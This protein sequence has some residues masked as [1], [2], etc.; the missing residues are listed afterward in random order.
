[1][2]I[3]RLRLLQRLLQPSVFLHLPADLPGLLPVRIS[4]CQLSYPGQRIQQHREL[5]K[6]PQPVRIS[7]L[8]SFQP[9][10]LQQLLYLREHTQRLLATPPPD[11]D[12][13]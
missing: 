3:A 10:A 7:Y 4:Q 11:P 5:H 6:L 13:A 9:A 2:D 8:R 1:M 12:A